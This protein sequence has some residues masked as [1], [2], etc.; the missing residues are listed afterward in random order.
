MFSL[1]KLFGKDDKF[2]RLMEASAEE[3]R[4]SIQSLIH[5]LKAPQEK[6][7]LDAFVEARRKDKRITKELTEHLLKTF[8]TPLERED[9]EALA[10]AL[11]KIP[12]TVEK[13]S[14]RLLIA[15]QQVQ[16]VDFSKQM[17]MLGKAADTVV[18]LVQELR[19]GVNLEKV[20]AQNDQLQY[21]EGEADKLMLESLRD[22]YNGD[23][24]TIKV[25]MLKDLYEILEKVFDRCRDT[26][27][28][29]FNIV[30]KHS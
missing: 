11:Y 29:V 6:R 1:Q 4:T 16:G 23:H 17:E 13:F 25:I 7:S 20:K 22:L 2:F 10:E 5:L 26:G 27:N 9:I 18:L 12:K 24:A 15:N 14:E 19:K 8:V 30:L 28:I 3:C 21:I